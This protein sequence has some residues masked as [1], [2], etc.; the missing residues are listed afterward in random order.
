[1]SNLTE[2]YNKNHKYV[3]NVAFEIL[4]PIYRQANFIDLKSHAKDVSQNV[5][6]KIINEKLLEKHD[7]KISSV[8]TFLYLVTRSV[9]YDYL[10]RE[11]KHRK[12]KNAYPEYLNYH[13]FARS[14]E[15]L[16]NSCVDKWT[17][18]L[19]PFEKKLFRREM[20][21]FFS[22]RLSGEDLLMY[23]MILDDLTVNEIAKALGRSW[24]TIE[25]RVGFMKKEIRKFMEL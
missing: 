10:R 6:V 21:E 7:E 23:E 4:R 3:E 16:E 9:A 12:S 11:N 22:S 24:R 19:N 5:W 13:Y 15:L 18:S 8:P 20:N 14:K 1:M 2:F 17:A 25:K